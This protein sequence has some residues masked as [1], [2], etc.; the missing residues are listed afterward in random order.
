MSMSGSEL[1]YLSLKN[2]D[3]TIADAARKE[4]VTPKSLEHRLRRDSWNFSNFVLFEKSI[5]YD[6]VIVDENKKFII[7]CGA[8]PTMDAVAEAIEKRGI[9]KK[10]I[11]EKLSVE[12]EDLETEISN[13][14]IGILRLQE[15]LGAFGCFL[16]VVDSATR[17]MIDPTDE[18]RYGTILASLDMER[19]RK[20]DRKG[21]YAR[22]VK[23][24]DQISIRVPKGLRQE[25]MDF[26]KSMGMSF[27][28][29]LIC[30]M[31][32][33]IE[34]GAIPDLPDDWEPPQE[35]M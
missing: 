30:L 27:T 20:A 12:V 33:A 18:Q 35:A 14:T 8:V 11:A 10:A 5:A 3:I 16:T 13:Q 1:A 17:K 2:R 6:T 34:T 28:Q 29:L 25:Y 24:Y 31:E 4:G 22:N 21:T 15:I 26:A 7:P 32:N 9:E 19:S 23:N